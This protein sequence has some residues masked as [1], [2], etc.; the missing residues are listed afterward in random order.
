MNG[1]E[2]VHTK[3]QVAHLDLKLENLLLDKNFN[4]KI[5][6]FGFAEDINLNVFTS[7]GTVGYKAPEIHNLENLPAFS[8]R[9]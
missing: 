8:D 5:C 4:L 6:D 2:Q 9:N 1:L 3:G 7:K